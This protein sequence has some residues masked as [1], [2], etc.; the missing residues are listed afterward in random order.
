MDLVWILMF[1]TFFALVILR[2]PVAFALIFPSMLYIFVFDVPTYLIARR[3]S[4][5][6]FSFSLLSVPLFIFTGTLLNHS[7]QTDRIFE[8]AKDAVGHRNGGLAYVNILGSLVF[9]G[10]SG[11]AL[12]DVGGIGRV[13]IRSMTDNGYEKDY[14]AAITS[15]SATL[16][17]IFPPSIPL[18]IFGVLAQESVLDLLLAGLVPALLC[19]AML[20]VVTFVIGRQRVF[21][22]HDRASL[23][24]RLRSLL[25]SL[26]AIVTPAV[27]VGGMLTGIFGPSEVAAVAVLYIVAINYIVYWNFDLRFIWDAATEATATTIRVLIIVMA[28]SVFGWILAIEGLS[29]AVADF[30][31]I[32][33]GDVLLALLFMNLVLLVLGL[34]LEPLTALV[35]MIPVF[36]PP[37]V[38][39]GLS[40][41]HIGVIMVFNLMIGLLTPP[42]GLTLFVASDISGASIESIIRE[43][44]PYYGALLLTLA[45]IVLVPEL[46]LWVV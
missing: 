40:P 27:L 41:I 35:M 25:I 33:G 20:T 42:V 28:A 26:P 44:L 17:P 32:F 19:A 8:F 29:G 39:L 7:G 15:A 46:S 6:L 22:S 37:L 12:A 16:G 13:M 24:K 18:I 1:A 36:V 2:V 11:S 45:L 23:R 4:R 9:S 30:L 38:E 14:S 10:I 3:M 34:F 31:T 43:L 21:P 5:T